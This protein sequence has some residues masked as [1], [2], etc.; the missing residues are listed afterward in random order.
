M[1]TATGNPRKLATVSRCRKCRVDKAKCEPQGRIW[2]Q[3]CNRCTRMRHDC[4]PG[5]VSQRGQRQSAHQTCTRNDSAI[6]MDMDMDIGDV[7]DPWDSPSSQETADWTFIGGQASS[8]GSSTS[9][10]ELGLYTEWA[11]PS[12][13]NSELE[14]YTEWAQQL[15]DT[16]TLTTG[17]PATRGLPP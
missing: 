4:D 8:Q 6:D 5:S 7:S 13:D 14:V 11:Q 2:P 3:K 10:S 16:F 15:W 1:P 17:A 12:W 9:S